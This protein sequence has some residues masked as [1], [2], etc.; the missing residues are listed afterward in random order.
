MRSKLNRHF[1]TDIAV[2][3]LYSKPK[4]LGEISRAQFPLFIFYLTSWAS[5]LS[6]VYEGLGF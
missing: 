5:L 4:N 2:W 1:Y 6:S 3:F